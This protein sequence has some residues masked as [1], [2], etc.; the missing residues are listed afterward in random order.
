MRVL[1]LTGENG[2]LFEDIYGALQV[3][4]RF[5]RGVKD[6]RAI[7]R[8]YDA[9]DAVSDEIKGTGRRRL[10]EDG[11]TVRLENAD[12]EVFQRAV[13]LVLDECNNQMTAATQVAYRTLDARRSVRALD[14]IEQAEVVDPTKPAAAV[15]KTV[16][17]PAS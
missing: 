13:K 14:V 17:A 4:E 2:E 1:T 12:Y 5:I 9:L 15:E 3:G 8:A 10:K 16:A 7:I 11:G 6:Q